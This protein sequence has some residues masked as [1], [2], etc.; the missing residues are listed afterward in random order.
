MPR[1]AILVISFIAIVFMYSQGWSNELIVQW[2]ML[3]L[4]FVAITYVFISPILEIVKAIRS[5]AQRRKMI[6]VARSNAPLDTMTWQEFE[7]Y[8]AEWLVKQGY[9][10]VSANRVL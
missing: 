9:K 6:R 4:F 3:G 8:V 10:D 2:I 1:D 7:Y 5:G